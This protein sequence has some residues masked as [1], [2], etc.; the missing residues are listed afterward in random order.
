MRAQSV[1]LKPPH[2]SWA[3]VLDFFVSGIA[4][5]A[6]LTAALAVL[7]GGPRYP[8]IVKAG[9]LGA[10]PLIA[11][12]LGLLIVDLGLP[13]RFLHMLWS[14]K[15]AGAIGRAA[16]TLGDFHF[17]PLS[18]MSA[19]AWGLLA[20]AGLAFAALVLTWIAPDLGSHWMRLLVS[21]FG[22]FLALF[23][24]SYKGVLLRAT[25]QPVWSGSSWLGP[26]FLAA[27]VS[28]GL[29]AVAL[30]A[31]FMDADP[32]EAQRL[33]RALAVAL[34]L[35][36]LVLGLWL[37]DLG[38]DRRGPTGLSFWVARTGAGLLLPLGALAAGLLPHAALL[39]LA[40]GLYCRYLVVTAAQ[41]GAA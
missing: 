10:F 20:F 31:T 26:L 2:W 34:V 35:E 37:W 36:G 29:A 19:G 21:L 22:G 39:T 9:Y 11:L 38:A 3:I 23:V 14:K 12:S 17:K 1:N 6:Y 16:L 18:P 27:A 13:R 30:V 33:T 28:S 40:G 41:R 25:A 5:G 32:H 8:K 7:A 4:A 15:G 24:G